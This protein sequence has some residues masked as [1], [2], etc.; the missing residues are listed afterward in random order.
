MKRDDRS[1][2]EK[3]VYTILDPDKLAELFRSGGC[4][5]FKEGKKWVTAKELLRSAR[6]EGEVVPVIFAPAVNIWELTHFADLDD[7]KIK[8]SKDGKWST[9]V[10]V[11]NL[12]KIS[13]PRRHKTSL[14]V[15]STEK[16]LPNTH[17]RPYV[18]V[19]TPSFL[20]R[21]QHKK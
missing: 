4:G 14:R 17:I 20:I 7:V 11:S 18:I 6:S 10:T 13:T 2:S 9:T 8:Q 16:S 21:K 5:E 19:Y 1:L 12:M 3:S 15:C